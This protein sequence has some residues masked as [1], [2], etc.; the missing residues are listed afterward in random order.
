MTGKD[1]QLAGDTPAEESLQ[2]SGAGGA[3]DFCR[4]KLNIVLS[5]LIVGLLVQIAWNFWEGRGL[6]QGY[7]FNTFLFI[8]KARFSDFVEPLQDAS[9]ANPYIYSA[10][11]PLALV[12]ERLLTDMPYPY[13]LFLVFFAS[14]AGVLVVLI[15]ALKPLVRFPPLRVG[16]SLVLLLTNYPVL[17]C[18]D[19]GNVDILMLLFIAA[20]LLCFARGRFWFCMAWLLPAISMKVYP[21]IYLVLLA[22]QRKWKLVLLSI[23][24]VAVFTAA[25]VAWLGVPVDVA[26]DLQRTNASN[27]LD[28]YVFE[29]YSIE[30]SASPWNVYK[31]G[32]LAA[33]K[34]GWISPIDFCFD[35][36]FLHASYT[37]YSTLTLLLVVY[38]VVHVCVIER[39]VLRGAAILSLFL[40]MASPSGADYRLVFVGV[41]LVALISTKTKRPLDLLA[42]VLMALVLVPKKEFFFDFAGKTESGFHDVSIQVVLNPFMVLSALALIVWNGCILFNGR[43]TALRL[44]GLIASLIPWRKSATG[45]SSHP[46]S[47]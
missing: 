14:M 20:A 39:E 1:E 24:G 33:E 44:R 42:L 13:S 3:T 5:I 12:A 16:L 21:A 38:L 22:R 17:Y 40:S 45:F 2:K 29:N 37:W 4:R 6:G 25:S 15:A 19:R 7:P 28:M 27:Y 43:W 9:Q 11:F 41:A 8:G 23:L 30:G 47:V 46:S 31:I 34:M 18:F 10:Y 32:L 35:S 26:A 36:P